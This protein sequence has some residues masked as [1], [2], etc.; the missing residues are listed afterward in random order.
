MRRGMVYGVFS[1]I[2][3]MN[4]PLAAYDNYRPIFRKYLPAIQL[5]DQ[6][7]WNPVTYA[8]ADKKE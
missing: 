5:A 6:L 1:N 4:P 8:I 2:L 3:S 7:G